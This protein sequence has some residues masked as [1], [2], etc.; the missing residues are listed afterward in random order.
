MPTTQ[1]RNPIPV[2][3]PPVKQGPSVVVIT[4][5]SQSVSSNLFPKPLLSY[6]REDSYHYN[7]HLYSSSYPRGH[8]NTQ[9]RTD[10]SDIL[11]HIRNDNLMLKPKEGYFEQEY[12]LEFFKGSQFVGASGF[13]EFEKNQ[14]DITIITQTSYC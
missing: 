1:A 13:S 10:Y 14:T 3:S 5:S 2:S 6:Q 11:V 9:K 8:L 7:L 12:R 4:D